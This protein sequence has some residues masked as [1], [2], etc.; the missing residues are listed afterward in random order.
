M[1]LNLKSYSIQN[2]T[3]SICDVLSRCK[4]LNEIESKLYMTYRY[5]YQSNTLQL[6]KN[7]QI[8]TTCYLDI[9]SQD[10]F[11]NSINH[12][13]SRYLLYCV[14]NELWAESFVSQYRI[15]SHRDL[16]YF[17]FDDCEHVF[18]LHDNCDINNLLTLYSKF[19]EN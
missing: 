7:N 3:F 9:T 4:L 13:I 2:K 6:V 5:N 1:K 15:E 14:T 11:I 12:S 10:S 19:V 17:E 16:V 8:L 18:N